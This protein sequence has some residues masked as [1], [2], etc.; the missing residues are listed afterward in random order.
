[1]EGGR[2]CRPS[3]LVVVVLICLDGKLCRASRHFGGR[4]YCMLRPAGLSQ[5]RATGEQSRA[6]G[7]KGVSRQGTSYGWGQKKIYDGGRPGTAINFKWPSS[8]RSY[9]MLSY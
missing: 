9:Q 6:T 8:L 7:E 5:R 4:V 2:G 1:M 3:E